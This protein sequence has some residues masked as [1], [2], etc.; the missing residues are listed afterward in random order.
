MHFPHGN[1]VLM[2][3]FALMSQS[4]GGQNWDAGSIEASKYEYILKRNLPASA[5]DE[6]CLT[7]YGMTS[8]KGK[9]ETV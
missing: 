8:L 4:S 3:F 1:S 2:M 6:F 5:S 9:A 7:Q